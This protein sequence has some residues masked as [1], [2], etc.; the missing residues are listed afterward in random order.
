[1][2]DLMSAMSAAVS[3]DSLPWAPRMARLRMEHPVAYERLRLLVTIATAVRD[4]MRLIGGSVADGWLQYA[5][6]LGIGEVML[7]VPGGSGPPEGPYLLSEDDDRRLR[8]LLAD[9]AGRDS[10][11]GGDG[12]R[13]HLEGDDAALLAIIQDGGEVGNSYYVHGKT[14]VINEQDFWAEVGEADPTIQF[15]WNAMENEELRRWI[16]ELGVVAVDLEEV[17]VDLEEAAELQCAVMDML[18]AGR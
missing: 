2:G 8:R 17:A 10:A 13:Y 1:M 18:L 6:E 12:W 14:G 11:E 7:A 5:T 3:D 9:H 16:D 15:Y 4:E